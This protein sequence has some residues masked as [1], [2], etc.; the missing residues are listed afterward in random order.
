LQRNLFF[1]VIAALF[2]L[3][4][5]LR[6]QADAFPDVAWFIYVA[7]QLLHGKTLYVDIMEVNPPLGIWLV[8]PGVWIAEK[9]NIDGATAVYATMIAMSAVTIWLCDRSLQF[10]EVISKQTRR[11][12]LLI[13]AVAILFLPGAFFGEREHFMPLLFLPWLFLRIVP[14]AATGRTSAE[15]LFI[16]FLA[17][18]AICIKPHSIFAP[19][20]VEFMLFL[21]CRNIRSFVAVEN[22]GATLFVIFYG[23]L[24][25]FFAPKFLSEMIELGSKAYVPFYGN[26]FVETLVGTILTI[27]PFLMAIFIRYR[28]TLLKADTQFLD[29]LL[30]AVLGFIVS[31]FVQMKGFGY[32]ILPADILASIT[33]VS[34]AVIL[35]QLQRKISATVVFAICISTLLVLLLPQTIS[36]S[37]KTW[38]GIVDR[39]APQAKSLFIASTKLS[40]GFPYVQRRNIVWASTLPS[41]WLAP[42]VD[43]KWKVGLVPQDAIVLRALNLTVTD[44]I[45]FKPD[46]VIIDTDDQIYV[47]S[48]KFEYIKFW[49]NDER[50]SAVWNKYQYRET[51]SGLEVYTLKNP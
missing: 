47:K 7:D 4:A 28:L 36:R 15:L 45:T 14:N 51:V 34:G 9:L 1:V 39:N 29:G 50:F 11:L 32:Q 5:Y 12:I 24:I 21:R 13:V 48:G 43:S 8:V 25:W 49:A 42:Y 41:Q 27:P 31:Y 33:S 6:F 37:F 44:L 19:L 22:F 35:W 18:A 40:D 16:G 10:Y 38:D 46:I 3:Q 23:L 26:G 20:L 30:M 17:G 2:A